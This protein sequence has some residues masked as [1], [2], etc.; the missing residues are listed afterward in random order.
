MIVVAYT[1]IIGLR[2][3]LQRQVEHLIEVGVPGVVQ[4]TDIDYQEQAQKAIEFFLQRKTVADY[5]DCPM[6]FV[7]VDSRLGLSFL[8][9]KVEVD[10]KID[11][12]GCL[13]I[14]EVILGEELFVMQYQAGWNLKSQSPDQ[15]INGL[16]PLEQPMILAEGLTVFLHQGI[17][18]LE[19]CSMYLAGSRTKTGCIP[20]LSLWQNRYGRWIPTLDEVYEEC[21]PRDDSGVA[22]RTKASNLVFATSS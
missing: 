15:A 1:V 10:C 20:W 3:A 9:E 11:L 6:E 18:L 19:S 16:Y 22:T 17:P 5:P 13:N 4:M 7:V 14:P 2:E 12:A 21:M 8:A